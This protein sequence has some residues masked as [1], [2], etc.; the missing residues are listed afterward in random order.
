VGTLPLR[1]GGQSGAIR[2][3]LYCLYFPTLLRNF[4]AAQHATIKSQLSHYR[5]FPPSPI[6]FRRTLKIRVARWHFFKPKKIC[7]GKFWKVLQWT[8]WVN[9]MVYFTAIGY[10]LY[11]FGI[12]PGYLVIFSRFWYVLPRQIWQP[13]SKFVSSNAGQGLWR[14]LRVDSYVAW[15]PVDKFGSEIGTTFFQVR[16][17]KARTFDWTTTHN[18]LFIFFKATA[19]PTYTTIPQWQ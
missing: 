4:P 8:M 18:F 2:W 1:G 5:Y 11:P 17:G 9:L 7:L 16:G 12:F 6:F 3:I 15:C 14:N 10:A 13:C 19:L